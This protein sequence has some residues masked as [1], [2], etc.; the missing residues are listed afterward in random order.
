MKIF[1]PQMMIDENEPFKNDVLKREF[2]AHKLNDI[3]LNADD[4]LVI[5]IN[6]AWGEGKTT[7]LKM[8]LSLIDKN[9]KNSIYLI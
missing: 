1:T 9:K 6:A 4:S 7:F 8:F 3:I 5:S 2:F